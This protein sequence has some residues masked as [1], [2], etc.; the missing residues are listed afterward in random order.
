MIRYYVAGDRPFDRGVHPLQ[1]A[2]GT[3]AKVITVQRISGPDKLYGFHKITTPR[4][5][6]F[7]IE[8]YFYHFW[9][10]PRISKGKDAPSVK[11]VSMTASPSGP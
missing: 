4:I 8:Q 9:E 11:V 10:L 3:K 7:R 1:P 5:G 2:E 6:M